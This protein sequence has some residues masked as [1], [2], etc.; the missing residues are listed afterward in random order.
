[1]T[2][3]LSPPLGAGQPMMR[4]TRRQ[5]GRGRARMGSCKGLGGL[6]ARTKSRPADVE[7]DGPRWFASTLRCARPS[8]APTR[9]P[10]RPRTRLAARCEAVPVQAAAGRV[11]RHCDGCAARADAQAGPGCGD[12]SGGPTRV[13]GAPL[14]IAAHVGYPGISRRRCLVPPGPRRGPARPFDRGSQ[15][16][17]PVSASACRHGRCHRRAAPLSGLLSYRAVDAAG[18]HRPVEEGVAVDDR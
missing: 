17:S 15:P 3:T 13:D 2:R 10:C 12:R 9:R 4:L 8:A 16:S 14:T 18:G 11:H 5:G 1:M 7:P 6:A